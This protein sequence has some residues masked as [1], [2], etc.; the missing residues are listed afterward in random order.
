MSEKAK[1]IVNKMMEADAFSQ[2]LGIN[3][4]EVK[5]GYCKLSMKVRSEMCNGFGITHGGI[6][7]SF[8]DSALAFA[9]NGYGRQSVALECSISFPVAVK[10]DDELTATATEIS[11]SYKIG[12]YNVVVRNQNNDLV[13]S[14]KGTVYRT[15]KDWE[16]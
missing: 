2:W 6:T 3:V 5:E 7:F 1:S 11:L 12:I 10:V 9:S 8:A 13:A 14:F 15:S 4:V 16:L